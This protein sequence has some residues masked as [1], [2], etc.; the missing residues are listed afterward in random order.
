MN[1]ELYIEETA[2][3]SKTMPIKSLLL[4][5]RKLFL[6]EEITQSN[7]ISFIQALMYL[8][9]DP[10][11][12]N[13]YI[14][15]PGGEVD[16]GLA[17]YDALKLCEN[18]IN[19]YCVGLAASMAAVIFAAGQKGRRFIL[20]HGRVMI[21]EVLVG[22]GVSGSASSFSKLTDYIIETR[23]LI[24]GILAEHT[25]KTLKEINKATSF[26]NFMNAKQAIEFGVCDKIADSLA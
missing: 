12:I 6:D 16:A 26:D 19:T 5:E 14:S 7:A 23:D 10:R 11:P 20:P 17:I 9:K 21:H 22:R 18:E 3:G 25:G 24:N 1:T 13:L 8:S 2:A 15:S 4:S